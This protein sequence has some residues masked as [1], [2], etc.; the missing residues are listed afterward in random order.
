MLSW[1]AAGVT[2]GAMISSDATL[3]HAEIA[4]IV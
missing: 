2:V 3:R 1:F 4:A